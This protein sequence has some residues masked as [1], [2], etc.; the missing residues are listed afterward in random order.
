MATYSQL[1]RRA[2]GTLAAAPVPAFVAARMAKQQKPQPVVTAKATKPLP[3]FMQGIAGHLKAQGAPAKPD[4]NVAT[5][6]AAKGAPQHTTAMFRGA[7]TQPRFGP[8]IGPR[9]GQIASVLTANSGFGGL[10]DAGLGSWFTAI[11]DVAKSIIPKHTVVGKMIGSTAGP[12][13][14]SKPA[15]PPPPPPT[16]PQQVI[17]SLTPQNESQKWMLGG[18]AVLGL[19]LLVL[20]LRRR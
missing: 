19:G 18:A 4:G 7:S 17:Q 13:N 12:L 15:P 2:R 3:T 5:L 10:G 8:V 16:M 6:L 20:V 9:S 11:V 14:P 1:S